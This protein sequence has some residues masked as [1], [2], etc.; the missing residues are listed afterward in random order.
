MYFNY[1]IFIGYKVEKYDDFKIK[2]KIFHIELFFGMKY[3][4]I[5]INYYFII[6]NIFKNR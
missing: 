3:V 1:F 2:I 4:S 6:G 5:M